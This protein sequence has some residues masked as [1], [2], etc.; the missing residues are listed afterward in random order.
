M[1]QPGFGP[2][3][4][5][6]PLGTPAQAPPALT[7]DAVVSPNGRFFKDSMGQWHG[8]GRLSFAAAET[9]GSGGSGPT[10]P[11]F[12]DTQAGGFESPEQ[13]AGQQEE[14]EHRVLGDD[15]LRRGI[16]AMSPGRGAAAPRFED[17]Q[18]NALDSP[19][20]MTGR[21]GPFGRLPLGG[22]LQQPKTSGTSPLMFMT[23]APG[24]AQ[25][26][27]GSSKSSW[28][29]DGFMSAADAA[30]LG[31]GPAEMMVGQELDLFAGEH[32]SG[33]Q[34]FEDQRSPAGSVEGDV[35]QM[36]GFWGGE[37]IQAPS[38]VCAEA[39]RDE[40]AELGARRDELI[41][42][43]G[44]P[45]A[46]LG[47]L[48]GFGSP[49]TTTPALPEV[50]TGDLLSGSEEE[51]TVDLLLLGSVELRGRPVGSR[52]Q[53]AFNML[54]AADGH[55]FGKRTIKQM[56]EFMAARVQMSNGRVTG[57][58]N[59]EVGAKHG[60]REYWM[61]AMRSYVITVAAD[62]D[63]C[64][65]LALSEWTRI[66]QDFGA[67]VGLDGSGMDEEAVAGLLADLQAV[68]WVYDGRSVARL[69]RAL[70]AAPVGVTG[71]SRSQVFRR[72]G[73]AVGLKEQDLVRAGPW[74]TPPQ[75]R[76][77]D[78]QQQLVAET[79]VAASVMLTPRRERSGS[80]EDGEGEEP[81]PQGRVEVQ[82]D[83]QKARGGRQW[84]PMI[85]E[86][87]RAA[88]AAAVVGVTHQRPAGLT[89][90]TVAG[91]PM[92]PSEVGRMLVGA[93]SCELSCSRSEDDRQL[94]FGMQFDGSREW[95]D[96][97]GSAVSSGA[98]SQESGRAPARSPYG[99]RAVRATAVVT[100]PDY[101]EGDMVETMSDGSLAHAMEGSDFTVTFCQSVGS[102]R[103]ESYVY[104]DGDE[105]QG[106]PDTLGGRLPRVV[107]RPK[108]LVPETPSVVEDAQTVGL[109]GMVA[110][111]ATSEA[112]GQIGAVGTVEAVGVVGA[113]AE[114]GL[115]GETTEAGT[116][117]SSPSVGPSEPES[118]EETQ[119]PS[120]QALAELQRS[121]V[122]RL[123][124][125]A[126]THKSTAVLQGEN[127][128]LRNELAEQRK[129][130]QREQGNAQRAAR[131]Q[132]LADAARERAEIELTDARKAHA[133]ERKA[134]TREAMASQKSLLATNQAAADATVTLRQQMET[135]RT[136]L[137]KQQ[138][139]TVGHALTALQAE[140]KCKQSDEICR[141]LQGVSG[142]AFELATKERAQ[143]V[144]AESELAGAGE[145]RGQEQRGTSDRGE[146]MAGLEE[147]TRVVAG[148][149]DHQMGESGR[150]LLAEVA[151]MKAQLASALADAAKLAAR[152]ADEAQAMTVKLREEMQAEMTAWKAA[153]AANTVTGPGAEGPAP[154][155]SVGSVV[156]EMEETAPSQTLVDMIQ[157]LEDPEAG[158]E[159]DHTAA[160]ERM[161]RLMEAVPGTHQAGQ[162]RR[163]M[164]AELRRMVG[165]MRDE[166]CDLGCDRPG[167]TPAVTDVLLEL[168]SA[169]LLQLM[170]ARRQMTMRVAAVVQ[171][172][173]VGDADGY[174]GRS[175]ASDP[176]PE[177]EPDE[178]P[179]EAGPATGA[180]QEATNPVAVRSSGPDGPQSAFLSVVVH[181]VCEHRALGIVSDDDVRQEGQPGG[182]TRSTE[183]LRDIR[184]L[185]RDSGVPETSSGSV[186][187]E[188]MYALTLS[189]AERYTPGGVD[190]GTVPLVTR[191]HLAEEAGEWASRMAGQGWQLEAAARCVTE[192]LHK[193]GLRVGGLSTELGVDRL[194]VVA[195]DQESRNHDVVAGE[196][197]NVQFVVV[198][199]DGL[200]REAEVFA[201]A[202]ARAR[203]EVPMVL[204]DLDTV[205][206]LLGDADGHG[207]SWRV[208]PIMQ[209]PSLMPYPAF[210][211]WTGSDR[212]ECATA[213]YAL[214]VKVIES[215]WV[216]GSDGSL[217]DRSVRS[218]QTVGLQRVLHVSVLNSAAQT[219][220]ARQIGQEI[221]TLYNSEL[222]RA[223]VRTLL[224]QFKGCELTDSV[225]ALFGIIEQHVERDGS[226]KD[227][228]MS[229]VAHARMWQVIMASLMSSSVLAA[230]K[231]R[232]Q[233]V[234]PSMA[235]ER[236]VKEWT[237]E[238]N[239]GVREGGGTLSGDG[240]LRSEQGDVS[241]K[242][243]TVPLE[244]YKAV[245][246]DLF[247]ARRQPKQI[248]ADVLVAGVLR[249]LDVVSIV[250]VH[251]GPVH[252][253]PKLIQVVA[254]ALGDM[255]QLEDDPKFV[256]YTAPNQR[257]DGDYHYEDQNRVEMC[258][259]LRALLNR[260]M[261]Q[262]RTSVNLMNRDHAVE[263]ARLRKLLDSFPRS[264][265]EFGA[266]LFATV[267]GSTRQVAATVDDTD[268][269]LDRSTDYWVGVSQGGET[270]EAYQVGH[271][272][273]LRFWL[274]CCDQLWLEPR[275]G[276][277]Q[278]GVSD[279]RR[280][281][282]D[283]LVGFGV[284]TVRQNLVVTG[285][286]VGAIV[287]PA[288]DTEQ[289]EDD[290]EQRREEEWQQVSRRGRA[291]AGDGIG[292]VDGVYET[293]VCDN[294]GRTGHKALTCVA[295]ALP[296]AGGNAAVGLPDARSRTLSNRVGAALRN[297]LE[298]RCQALG[299]GRN[300]WA[301]GSSSHN[302]TVASVLQARISAGM[303][304]LPSVDSSGR[305]A[306]GEMPPVTPDEWAVYG[307]TQTMA[308]VSGV[309]NSC[310]H[311]GKQAC[312]DL[313][314]CQW[315]LLLAAETRKS[316]TRMDPTVQEFREQM[317]PSGRGKRYGA[318]FLR[319]AV[320]GPELRAD[321]V[322]ALATLKAAIGKPQHIAAVV[323]RQLQKSTSAAPAWMQTGKKMGSALTERIAVD[324]DSADRAGRNKLQ[325]AR[326]VVFGDQAPGGLREDVHGYK[327]GDYLRTLPTEVTQM[328]ESQADPQP[329]VDRLS[330][331][332][333]V[334]MVWVSADVRKVRLTGKQARGHSLPRNGAMLLTL[335]AAAVKP[336]S[337]N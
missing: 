199:S 237:R 63:G 224:E 174:E 162:R 101:S 85:T 256:G 132:T 328:L 156:T 144:A 326:A 263:A 234:S 190:G 81:P 57:V 62:D 210:P 159:A 139:E 175:E 307:A 240:S 100:L 268:R 167:W 315:R 78:G 264:I 187:S 297:L 127:S 6:V 236:V 257:A 75:E 50:P 295:E 209:Q 223:G 222:R 262:V 155:R 88:R 123:A 169:D 52:L 77:W 225:D 189:S 13:A 184:R 79:I 322:A 151:S 201:D 277:E 160:M 285:A 327:E 230:A 299:I 301:N 114:A 188:H 255:K 11:S 291:K 267:R 69:R 238:C 205:E 305:A 74:A 242:S 36:A 5:D 312:T 163:I 284:F 67:A 292:K 258:V 265:E 249:S 150:E 154:V 51:E 37:S 306:A 105:S 308:A 229:T 87:L 227:E 98:G 176:E 131:A 269:R 35:M 23:R 333:G 287:R 80:V 192:E 259:E 145:R 250:D 137:A 21:H 4:V 34:R 220:L 102:S 27:S 288:T 332:W 157:N 109:V 44:K 129:D 329:A 217:S 32:P 331:D 196:R 46:A 316:A 310:P 197:A 290:V 94:R 221:L 336:V 124:G 65:E 14:L 231:K 200:L 86:W 278:V 216:A 28:S 118:D 53:A 92:S 49:E 180:D 253:A 173:A 95:S 195:Q 191:M 311:C 232:G 313:Y 99:L 25:T 183:L 2:I 166:A 138:V 334:H 248:W 143:R 171:D 61:S 8:D 152:A 337:L 121:V 7:A 203:P 254:A 251:D 211:D 178:S 125:A 112:Q 3:A 239:A 130:L 59:T 213:V 142:S 271:M 148:L 26:D 275:Y 15:L 293:M 186:G 208:R 76:A 194:L 272:K 64:L 241:A 39:Q 214:A 84:Q 58:F 104:L 24:E 146:R 38:P 56:R 289:P 177:P 48:S 106:R 282:R 314:T 303:L 103:D 93:D 40:L 298:E 110:A 116:E 279:E 325:G 304:N 117:M 122:A 281:W 233:G 115:S 198:V 335:G 283:T 309:V 215:G 141:Q 170:S 273:S 113:T 294:C 317:M 70:L 83:G 60:T 323:M 149:G 72:F 296:W 243:S 119:T 91:A 20:Q 54:E 320:N 185:V 10:S 29:D 18:A 45:A 1:D 247:P 133:A 168:G 153:Q 235:V 120:T 31:A 147:Q 111:V 318:L 33:R 274:D 330:V 9:R 245:F 324:R 219:A 266:V 22:D 321:Y 319:G 82:A 158:A 206:R 212:Q 280:S 226:L 41:R 108:I 42:A 43:A 30:D 73:S 71:W 228:S 252:T 276:P 164:G 66:F 96:E 270:V 182:K 97:E 126:A 260:W 136:Q 244:R 12:T 300:Q 181:L 179:D 55:G 204:R 302:W 19:A 261:Q 107:R 165:Q 68:G 89:V 286:L 135:T 246:L 128:E 134:V 218:D 207:C 140:E 172:M 90:E 202:Q 161:R 16:S 47:R 17:W 193:V